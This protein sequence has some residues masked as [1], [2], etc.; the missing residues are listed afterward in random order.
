MPRQSR[1]DAPGAV[2]HINARG[3]AQKPIFIDDHGRNSILD[4][5]GAILVETK[6]PCY[7]WALIPNH[8]HLLLR[9]GSV[10]VTT[11]MRRLLTGYAISFNHR[12]WDHLFQ[13]R[14][15]SILCQRDQSGTS[16]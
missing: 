7:A 3:I 6:T 8:F 2:H 16:F 9:I 10:P 12:H 14:Y 11:V 15:K 4:R 13:S 5:L 1:I